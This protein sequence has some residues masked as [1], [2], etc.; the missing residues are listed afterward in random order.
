MDK[1]RWISLAVIVF[2]ILFLT[3][4]LIFSGEINDISNE[5]LVKGIV[6]II[7]WLVLSLGCIWYGDELGEGLVGA[8]YGLVS[9]SSPGWAVQLIGWILL[10]LP[11]GIGLWY[12]FSENKS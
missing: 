1:S 11:A 7:F 3:V 12:F 4:G 9:E 8:K 5:S 10:L 2:Y 6:G